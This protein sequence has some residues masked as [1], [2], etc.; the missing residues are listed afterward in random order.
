MVTVETMRDLASLHCG[1]LWETFLR[2]FGN[3]ISVLRRTPVCL[4]FNDE[5][6]TIARELGPHNPPHMV[7]GVKVHYCVNPKCQAT[8]HTTTF[9]AKDSGKKKAKIRLHCRKCLARSEWL[10]I[11]D[12]DWAHPVG[13][14]LA[15][16]HDFPVPPRNLLIFTMQQPGNDGNGSDLDSRQDTSMGSKKRGRAN[17]S[18]SIDVKKAKGKKAKR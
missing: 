10:L 14:G 12:V 7:I 4:I 8:N 3:N 17:T 5:Q 1:S 6:G 11:S 9:S 16:W 13:N 18:L 2:N 15:F